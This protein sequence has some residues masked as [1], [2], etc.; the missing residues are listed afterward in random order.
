MLLGEGIKLVG[1]AACALDGGTGKGVERVTHHLVAVD[2]SRNASVNLG[3]GHL[4]V[5]DEIPRPCGNETQPKDAIRGVGVKGV[6]GELFLHKTGVGLILV[7]GADDIVAVGPGIGPQLI[8]VVAAGVGV[9]HH[10]QPVPAPAFAVM[11]GGQ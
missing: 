1:V 6:A 11:R 4:N 9:L 5:P 10:I 7:E 3:L 8:L 2:V